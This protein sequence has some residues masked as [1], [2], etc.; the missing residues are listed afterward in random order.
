MILGR[1]ILA[2]AYDRVPDF[3]GSS[4][5]HANFAFSCASCK[6]Q[7][8]VLIDQLID[9]AWTWETAAQREV[10]PA[11]LTQA[12]EAFEFNLVGRSHDGGMPL[13]VFPHC[14]NC[15]MKYVLYAGVREPSNSYY[16]VTVQ[17]ISEVRA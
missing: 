3:S 12:K 16:V 13:L 11:L 7:V 10:D 15:G 9:A 6:R 14:S 5:A 8:V 2:P 4:T 1:T 17:G